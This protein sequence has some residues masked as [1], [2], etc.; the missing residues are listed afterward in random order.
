MKTLKIIIILI[1]FI[2]S[3]NI[4]STNNNRGVTNF[5][6]LTSCERYLLNTQN[7]VISDNTLCYGYIKG[8]YE[9]MFL[10]KTRAQNLQ[11]A[12]ALKELSKFSSTFNHTSKFSSTLNQIKN[13]NKKS[14]GNKKYILELQSELDEQLKKFHAVS[15]QFNN[16]WKTNN[17][18][19]N[20]PI[21]SGKPS[22]LHV[23]ENAIV[24]EG[25]LFKNLPAFA[26]QI[27]A[28]YNMAPEVIETIVSKM[29]KSFMYTNDKNDK[30]G[31]NFKDKQGKFYYLSTWSLPSVK[32][33]DARDVY[34]AR[35]SIDCAFMPDVIVTET[36]MEGT[37]IFTFKGSPL[38]YIEGLP[39]N[40]MKTQELIVMME[41]VKLT[42]LSLLR[43]FVGKGSQ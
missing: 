40:S 27:P 17:K 39:H 29:K 21:Q 25:V 30:S 28:Y 38:P 2:K 42:A 24:I 19:W 36:P 43:A 16:L 5:E 13:S 10:Q 6:L 15:N 35:A 11:K 37:K 14:F 20:G 23:K 8:I 26:D 9:L 31:I 22:S 4:A 41:Y 3:S 7:E 12:I 33:K 34:F 1:I 18:Q 32:T